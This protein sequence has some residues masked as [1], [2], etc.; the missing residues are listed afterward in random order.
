MELDDQ[1]MEVM[2]ELI[3]ALLAGQ[4][5]QPT[6]LP[7]TDRDTVTQ[8]LAL[9]QLIQLSQAKQTRI[10]AQIAAHAVHSIHLEA[11]TVPATGELD[12]GD[13]RI[14]DMDA[15]AN[16]AAYRRVAAADDELLAAIDDLDDPQLETDAN[17]PV[18]TYLREIA[19]TPPLSADQV[20]RLCISVNTSHHTQKFTLLTTDDKITAWQVIYDEL[21][22]AWSAALE[23]CSTHNTPPP[24]LE[25]LLRDGRT[26][27]DDHTLVL[28]AY[29][30]PLGWGQDSAVE[31]IS[32]P[33]FEIATVALIFPPEF[34]A[35]LEQQ[36]AQ[37]GHLPTWDLARVWM[38]A[39]KISDDHLR[40]MEWRSMEA[41]DALERANL[42]LVVRIARRYVGRGISFMDLI[43]EGSIGLL[44]A[45][46][47]FKVASG[48]KF[49]TYATWWIRRAMSRAVTDQARSMR[50]PGHQSEP[51]SAR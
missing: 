34:V 11:D 33:L 47:N 18:R 16:T 43:Q 26:I 49:S 45:T 31:T 22:S 28:P 30:R 37:A 27:Q 25:A 6:S 50:I 24:S 17:D 29:L 51:P 38:P 42:R 35:Q 20:L 4:P 5:V 46:E 9:R 14:A 44:R 41:R 19:N 23:A 36:L 48:F 13:W 2:D 3:T 40:G 1:D 7:E 12:A 21:T 10:Q 32:E 15:A 8:V 39:A